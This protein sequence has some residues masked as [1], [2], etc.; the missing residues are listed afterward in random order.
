MEQETT[1]CQELQNDTAIDL[2]DNRGK[3]HKMWLMLLGVTLGLLRKR[4]GCL[5]SLHRSMVNKHDEE[6]CDSLGIGS[7]ELYPVRI[8]RFYLRR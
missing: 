7:D 3:R 4:D 8:C 5:S 2:R 1:F 6:L